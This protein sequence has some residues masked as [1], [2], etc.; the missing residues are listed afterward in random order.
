[1]TTAASGTS[2]PPKE[3]AQTIVEER[4]VK[5]NGDHVIKKYLKGKF[6]VQAAKIIMKSSLTKSRAKAKL[7]SEIKIHRSLHHNN[8]VGFEHFFEDAENV[9]ILLELCT[10]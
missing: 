8:I 3:D 10:N 4:I 6:L 1:M 7:M 5:F 2:V 9:Y